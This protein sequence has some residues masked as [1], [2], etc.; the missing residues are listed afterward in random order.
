MDPRPNQ[1]VD[2][3]S[4]FRSVKEAVAVFGHRLLIGDTLPPKPVIKVIN[5]ISRE[6][7]QQHVHRNHVPLS[8]QK[9][10]NKSLETML[11]KLAIELEEAKFEIKLLKERESETQVALAFVNA[12]LHRN[13]S[14]MVEAEAA[15]AAK[16]VATGSKNE[17]NMPRKERVERYL[18]STSTTL[19]EVLRFGEREELGKLLMMNKKKKKPI[20]PLVSEMFVR[21][22]RSSSQD[23]ISC[24]IYS[25]PM[26]YT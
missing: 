26:F 1:T 13:M 8:Y 24:S 23:D 25:S 6:R 14:R 10:D 2:T 3:S 11:K 7:D 4:P 9:D 5:E 17:K 16:A 22:K 19:G 21:K 18:S 15:E 12:L 20:V